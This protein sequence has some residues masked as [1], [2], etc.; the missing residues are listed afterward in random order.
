MTEPLQPASLLAALTEGGVDFV[1]VGAMAVGVHGEVRATGDL[2][3]MVPHG[4]EANRERL[5]AVLKRLDA[6]LIPPEQAGAQPN[7]TDSYPALMFRTRHGRLD[8]LYRPDGSAPY[9]KVKQRSVLTAIGGHQVRVAGRDDLIAMK[10][11]AGRAHDLIDVATLSF[12]GADQP[13]GR[14]SRLLAELALADGV[15]PDWAL[16]LARSRVGHFDP[17]AK[18]RVQRG[19]LTLDATRGDLTDDQLK[20]WAQALGE[21]LHGAGVLSS[22]RVEV[23]IQDP[24]ASR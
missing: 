24:Q 10:L 19:R 2:D 16:D 14:P 4:D 15:D 21:R 23:E 17:G 20:R 7:P 12:G 1:V 6:K 3:V 22:A 13:A 5:D 18:L 8:V 11:A 9:E